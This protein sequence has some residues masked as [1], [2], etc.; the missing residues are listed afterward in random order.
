ML[1]GIISM[2]RC[3]DPINNLQI[4]FCEI[5]ITYILSPYLPNDNHG[6][7]PPA[8]SLDHEA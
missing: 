7:D 1:L 6:P 3:D 5:Q 8:D 4:L 2:C